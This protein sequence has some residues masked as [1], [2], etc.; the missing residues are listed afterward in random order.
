[1]AVT[2]GRATAIDNLPGEMGSNHEIVNDI[3]KEINTGSGEKGGTP[4]D[5]TQIFQR[6]TDGLIATPADTLAPS[7]QQDIA[8][9]QAQYLQQ[10]SDMSENM[11]PQSGA[12]DH[13][14][15]LQ[16]DLSAPV[17]AMPLPHRDTFIGAKE[18]NSVPPRFNLVTFAKTVLL[19]MFVYILFSHRYVKT[20]VGKIPT[21]ST[22][23]GLS[24]IGTVVCA[25]VGGLLV[26]SV[27]MYV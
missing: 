3:L 26:A 10:Q 13:D 23:D 11:A 27:Q 7:N 2:G 1:M 4:T 16:G 14:T 25:A 5:G 9:M 8:E 20:M 17:G 24:V 18:E 12:P 22:E 21:F 6:Q 15:A 19:F